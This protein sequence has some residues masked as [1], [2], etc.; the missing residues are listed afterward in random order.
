MISQ[1]GL[2]AFYL[3]LTSQEK[4]RLQHHA[5]NLCTGPTGEPHL[6]RVENT[7]CFLWAVAANA[8]PAGDYV[9][10]RK[11]LEEAERRARDP[12]DLARVNLNL[13][14]LY[15]DLC[16]R[17]PEAE[18]KYLHYRAQLAAGPFAHWAWCLPEH[19]S[20]MPADGPGAAPLR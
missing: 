1:L 3:G 8:M 13:A 5:R 7:A 16:G 18:G 2:G 15:L 17:E 14:Q 6:F 10:A 12:E 19:C 20:N 9:L 11:A 4:G